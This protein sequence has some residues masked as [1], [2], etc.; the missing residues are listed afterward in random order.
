MIVGSR[1]SSKGQ[2]TVPKAIRDA[3]GLAE[4]DA[5]VFRVDGD[6]ATLARTPD[7]LDLAG[8]VPV[9]PEVRGASWDEIRS[10]TRAART[11]TGRG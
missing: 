10:V 5:V 8:T 4:G 9:P 6:R 1:M 7:L 11:G 3:L 2:V